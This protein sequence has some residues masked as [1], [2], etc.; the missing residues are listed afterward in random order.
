MEPMPR[1]PSSGSGEAV[2]GRFVPAVWSLE[3]A[4]LCAPAS[5]LVPVA[6]LGAAAVVSEVLEV[7]LE[8]ELLGAAALFCAPMLL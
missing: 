1:R 5:E 4:L 7:A 6:L 8:V 2:W 3:V